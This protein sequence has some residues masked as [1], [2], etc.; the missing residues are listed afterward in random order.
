MCVLKV[1]KKNLNLNLRLSG[2]HTNF[3][4]LLSFVDDPLINLITEAQ[5]VVFNA[6][7]G[8][9]LQLISG[10]N[11][12]GGRELLKALVLSSYEDTKCLYFSDLKLE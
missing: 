12:Q 11:L 9:H 2:K 5:S 1:T 7:V 4:V 10:E 8:D 6:E 3:D